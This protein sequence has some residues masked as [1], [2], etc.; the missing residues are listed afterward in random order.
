MSTQLI[1]IRNLTKVYGSG[2]VA[3]HALDGVDLSIPRG[4]FAAIM[5]PSGSGKSTLMNI[6]G[7]LDR[8][9]AGE[10]LLDG[11]DVSQ[12]GKNELAEVRNQKLGF[13]FQSFNLL[14]RLTALD[15]VMLPM[16]YDLNRNESVQTQ[17]E[18]AKAALESVGLGQRMHHRPPEL[19]GGQ[20]QRVAIARALV[21]NPPV[22]L[23][24]EPTGNL[25]SHSSE[26]VLDLLH[27]LN[28]Q[29]VTI[30]MVTHEHDIALHA[31]RI[32]WVHDGKIIERAQETTGSKVSDHSLAKEMVQ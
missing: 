28:E 24:D 7:C 10:Y 20:Q 9:T 30:V 32:I 22:I 8:P 12:L 5:G 4:E 25:D 2:E 15:N 26:E 14:P 3:V 29:G 21:N 13:I 31:Q 23:A 11:R 17:Q 6:L 27:Q 19:S 18:R 16:L 1:E